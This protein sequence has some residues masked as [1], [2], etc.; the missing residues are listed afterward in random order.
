LNLLNISCED[1]FDEGRLE[2]THYMEA[3]NKMVKT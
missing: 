1:C 2:Q 3:A